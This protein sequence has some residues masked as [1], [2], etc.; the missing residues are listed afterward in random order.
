MGSGNNEGAGVPTAAF[1]KLKKGPDFVGPVRLGG[2]LHE[3]ATKK[4]NNFVVVYL[5]SNLLLPYYAAVK[6]K[7]PHSV[8]VFM[9][10]PGHPAS[11]FKWRSKWWR[12]RES[13]PR[14]NGVQKA[15][16]DY[17]YFKGNAFR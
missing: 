17:S 12:W 5:S 16:N 7:H 9:L 3:A 10:R 14:P 1:S 4:I 6:S 15:I 2:S 13:N 11:N 8:Q